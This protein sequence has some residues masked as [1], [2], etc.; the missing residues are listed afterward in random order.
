M[1][2]E[3]EEKFVTNI[4]EYRTWSPDGKK[5]A[6][7]WPNSSGFC[8]YTVNAD[9]TGLRKIAG[10]KGSDYE[11]AHTVSQWKENM[12]SNEQ[13]KRELGNLEHECRRLG[14]KTFYLEIRS[15]VIE[16]RYY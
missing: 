1:I 13:E 8:I 5:L 3:K 7:H 4:V 16:L 10:A 2:L 11:I 14:S 15:I 12:L 6:F 9:G